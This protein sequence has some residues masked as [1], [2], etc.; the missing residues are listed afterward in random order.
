MARGDNGRPDLWVC[1]NEGAAYI[2]AG[3]YLSRSNPLA[4]HLDPDFDA[5]WYGWFNPAERVIRAVRAMGYAVSAVATS[6]PT[7]SDLV[8]EATPDVAIG[9]TPSGRPDDAAAA[10]LTRN[11]SHRLETLN[12]GLYRELAADEDAAEVY[13][14]HLI[15][16]AVCDG[17][18]LSTT[19]QTV[20]RQVLGRQ[21]P[22]AAQWDALAAEYTDTVLMAGSQRPGLI[23]VERPHQLVTYRSEF[24]LCR[25][26]ETL[27]C[28]RDE[29]PADV[30]YAAAM[31]GIP[32]PSVLSVVATGSRR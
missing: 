11:R 6:W 18:G 8:D 27:L 16:H 13:A 4:A 5:R 12:A 29:N 3:V 25:R 32:T 7:P 1:S 10:E 20:A 21:Y 24:E 31:A 9:V 15:Q 17:P 30:A 14:R 19:A 28:W 26:V 22:S 2:P 23:G